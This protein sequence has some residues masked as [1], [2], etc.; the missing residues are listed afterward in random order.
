MR[1]ANVLLAGAL[2]AGRAI[3]FV[4]QVCGGNDQSKRP[5]PRAAAARAANGKIDVFGY[6]RTYRNRAAVP[7]PPAML[8]I[9]RASLVR[10]GVRRAC[11]SSLVTRTAPEAP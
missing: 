3:V 9:A 4:L 7:M 6:S 1:M 8:I 5:R 10:S 2:V 11:A